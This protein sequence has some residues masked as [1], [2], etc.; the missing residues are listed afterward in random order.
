MKP[1][2][3]I[4]SPLYLPEGRR[5]FVIAK[6][7]A[8]RKAITLALWAPPVSHVSQT[9]SAHHADMGIEFYKPHAII[10]E[11]GISHELALPDHLLHIPIIEVSEPVN[12]GDLLEQVNALFARPR[13]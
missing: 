5:F 8:V 9:A 6:S 1:P 10:I 2:P 13:G 3:A 7:D 11:S 4:G 12:K